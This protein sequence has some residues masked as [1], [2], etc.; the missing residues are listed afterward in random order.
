MGDSPLQKKVDAERAARRE[1]IS[2]ENVEVLNVGP[3]PIPPDPHHL[4]IHQMRAAAPLSVRKNITQEMC[5]MINSNID[6]SETKQEFREH[7]IGWVD[8]MKEGKWKFKDYINACRYMTFKLMG[9]SQQSAWVKVFP[10]RFQKMIDSGQSDN[11]VAA[12]ISLYN[13]NPL[14][15]KIAERTLPSLHVMNSDILQEAINVSAELMRG[16][17][18]ETVRQKSA[19]TLIEHLKAPETLKVDL[20]VGVSND[21][22]EDLREITRGLAVQQQKMIQS[23]GM[24]AGQVAEM[25]VV[26]K[27]DEVLIEAEYEEM[28]PDKI[29]QKNPLKDFF[30]GKK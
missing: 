19:A 21:T 26:G 28:E 11:A 7:L 12:R 18:S 13:G 2:R 5:D 3:A 15:Q 30:P 22:V 27:R 24:S 8:V 23:G 20:N 9:D 17:K 10:D 16:A 4:T 25:S 29:S 1:A 14:V 6:D